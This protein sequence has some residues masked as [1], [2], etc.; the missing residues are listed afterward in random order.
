MA[1]NDNKARKQPSRQ[2]GGDASNDNEQVS[3]R[4]DAGKSA[5]PRGEA[6]IGAGNKI[7][8]D[9]LEGIIPGK[10]QSQDDNREESD[11]DERDEDQRK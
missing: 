4:E 2:S 9:M 1:D 11:D 7:H 10:S 3:N 5:G 8:G 6:I